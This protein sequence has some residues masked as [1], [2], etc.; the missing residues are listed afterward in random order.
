MNARTPILLA[1]LILAPLCMTALPA[2]AATKVVC[3]KTTFFFWTTWSCETPYEFGGPR[4]NHDNSNQDSTPVVAP[5]PKCER[6]HEH[7]GKN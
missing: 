6:H 4:Q 7:H 5:A 2:S 1:A 3:Q